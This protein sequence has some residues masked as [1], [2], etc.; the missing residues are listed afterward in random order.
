VPN[1]N[2]SE[3]MPE[4]FALRLDETGVINMNRAKGMTGRTFA[5]SRVDASLQPPQTCAPT[6]TNGNA[7]LIDMS[8]NAV[9]RDVRVFDLIP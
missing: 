5:I 6:V 2:F 3:Q 8:I 7:D 4:G 1:V 9:E